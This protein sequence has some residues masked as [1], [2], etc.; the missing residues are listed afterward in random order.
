MGNP[1]S[2]SSTSCLDNLLVERNY[3]NRLEYFAMGSDNVFYSLIYFYCYLA[4]RQY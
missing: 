2:L 4:F 3:A 1:Y